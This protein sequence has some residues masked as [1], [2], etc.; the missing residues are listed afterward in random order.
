MGRTRIF[1][2]TREPRWFKIDINRSAVNLPR[3]AFRIREKSAAAKPVWAWAARMVS[4]SRSRVFMIPPPRAPSTA[5]YRRSRGQGREIRSRYREP[6]PVFRLSSECLLQSFQPILHQV[7]LMFRRLDAL[8][9]FFLEC[10]DHPNLIRELDSVDHAKG[11]A[12]VRKG[13]LQ[14]AGTEA[15]QRFGDGPPFRLPLRS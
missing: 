9:R 3:S 5:R 12:A 14:H 7:D 6:T 13:D 10:V 2:S 15:V 11:V 4:S 1:T 8:L